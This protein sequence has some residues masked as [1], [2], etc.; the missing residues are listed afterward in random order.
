MNRFRAVALR[1]AALS[2]A[3]RDWLL[4]HLPVVARQ[5][6]QAELPA[7]RRLYSA[8]PAQCARWLRQLGDAGT[9]RAEPGPA[10]DALAVIDRASLQGMLQLLR[11]LPLPAQAELLN[12]RPWTWKLSF[13]EQLPESEQHRL[14]ARGHGTGLKPAVRNAL[15]QHM[16]A[17]LEARPALRTSGH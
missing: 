1:L 6:I 3:D 11:G 15:I 9:T 7:A 14:M 8:D 10:A 2:T 13:L 17:A 12:V 5:A 16:A 4:R